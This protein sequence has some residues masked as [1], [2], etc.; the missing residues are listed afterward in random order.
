VAHGVRR[1][2]SGTEGAHWLK[3]TH[4]KE[5]VLTILRRLVGPALLS[6]L[7]AGTLTANP[8][9]AADITTP[10]AGKGVSRRTVTHE[11][12]ASTC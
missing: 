12:A 6:L 7:V 2:C 3:R 5:A 8:A 1:P 4:P 9:F 10:F 11:L